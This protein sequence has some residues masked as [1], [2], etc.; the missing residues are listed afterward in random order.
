MK[1]YQNYYIKQ[2]KGLKVQDYLSGLFYATKDQ[3]EKAI[4]SKNKHILNKDDIKFVIDPLLIQ[5]YSWGSNE[6][7]LTY[8]RLQKV[9]FIDFKLR[10]YKAISGSYIPTPK[11]I[12]DTKS[13]KVFSKF[14]LNIFY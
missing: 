4:I 3:E 7:N 10:E 11:H 12:S 8:W 13:G 6:P 1:I 2:K 14:K 5:I 9:L